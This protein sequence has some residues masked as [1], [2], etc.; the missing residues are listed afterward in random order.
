MIKKTL[1]LL[2]SLLLTMAMI[3]P[4]AAAEPSEEETSE[5]LNPA[6]TLQISSVATIR[7]FAEN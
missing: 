2:I 4:V 3:L 6:V 5:V 1:S 7:R